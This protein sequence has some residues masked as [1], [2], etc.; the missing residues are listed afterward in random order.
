MRVGVIA[1]LSECVFVCVFAKAYAVNLWHCWQTFKGSFNIY[2][3]VC[4]GSFAWNKSLFSVVFLWAVTLKSSPELQASPSTIN[5]TRPT[6]SDCSSYLR[7]PFGCTPPSKRSSPPH[8]SSDL[9]DFSEIHLEPRVPQG[10]CVSQTHPPIPRAIWIHSHPARVL[11]FLRYL[12]RP[13]PIF[14]SYPSTGLNVHPQ[15]LRSVLIFFHMHCKIFRTILSSLDLFQNSFSS[16][17]SF[18]DLSWELQVQPLINPEIPCSDK[19][20]LWL[21]FNP[22]HAFP[23]NKTPS[24]L[25]F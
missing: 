19:L 18:L 4:A 17:W 25:K 5:T 15:F 21:P 11:Q 10:S 20:Q 23:N 12:L 7:I 16:I 6:Y 1:F 9:S 14:I 2:T 24:M 13:I 22:Y 8:G 3:I